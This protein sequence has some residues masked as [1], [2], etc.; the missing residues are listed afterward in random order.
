M[1]IFDTRRAVCACSVR[2]QRIRE[3]ISTNFSKIAICEN[4]DPRKFSAIRY[5][6]VRGACVKVCM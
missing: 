1:K 2:V 5:V 3:I 6:C 4:L